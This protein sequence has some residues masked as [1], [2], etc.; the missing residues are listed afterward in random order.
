VLHNHGLSPRESLLIASDSLDLAAGAATDPGDFVNF[1]FRSLTAL[2]EAVRRYPGDPEVWYTLGEK[3]SHSPRPIGTSPARRFEAFESAIALDSGFAP[4]YE[5]LVELAIALG[6]PELGRRYV[7][8]YVSLDPTAQSALRTRLIARMLDPASAGAAE[9]ARLIDTTSVH[10][11]FGAVFPALDLWPD[12][13]ETAIRLMRS[14]GEGGRS[15]GGDAPWVLDSL[16]WPQYLAV[17]LASRGH[18]HEAYETDK[19]L[20]LDPG[21]S[22]FSGFLDPFL[23]LSLL[24]A[25]PDSVAGAAFGRSLMPT[26]QWGYLITPRHLRGLPWWLAHRDTTSLARF[27]ARA[28]GATRGGNPPLVALRIRLLGATATSF[29]ALAR[30]DSAGALQ[31]LEAIPDTLCLADDYT[32]NCFY[33]NLTRAR[34]LAARGENRRA[35]DLLERWRWDAEGPSFALAT[36]ELARLAERLGEREKAVGSYQFVVDVWRR[37]DPELQPYV[38]EAREALVRLARLA[39]RE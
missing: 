6:R 19:R 5:H 20:L 14:M 30:G 37:A 9:T 10:T 2:E 7:E 21:A 8:A 33:L 34:L 31:Q 16:M 29:L 22:R 26:A 39:R 11:L 38:T 36:L 28:A 13:D 25:I 3:R 12:S 4:A 15:A 24:G 32:Q 27:A 23:D 17:T 18:L 1:S 35:F